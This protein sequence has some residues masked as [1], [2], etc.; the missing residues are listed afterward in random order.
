MRIAQCAASSHEGHEYRLAIGR[1]TEV[2]LHGANYCSGRTSISLSSESIDHISRSLPFL[3]ALT[4]WQLIN[5]LRFTVTIVAPMAGGLKSADCPPMPAYYRVYCQTTAFQTR[6]ILRKWISDGK[7][8]SDFVSSRYDQD[9]T[10]SGWPP[11]SGCAL[12]VYALRPQP[13]CC[14]AQR[15]YNW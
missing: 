4:T 5:Q 9:R 12:C 11:T 15:R 3:S 10:D 2:R 13:Y 7:A 14:R 6:A 8:S 1:R